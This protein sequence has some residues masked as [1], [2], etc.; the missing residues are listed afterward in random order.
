M[1]VPVY[2]NATLRPLTPNA[3][4]IGKRYAV[5]EELSIPRPLCSIQAGPFPHTAR[6]TKK[7]LLAYPF[8]VITAWSLRTR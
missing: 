6:E 3:D 2:E 8:V 5:R 7:G 4:N 1:P